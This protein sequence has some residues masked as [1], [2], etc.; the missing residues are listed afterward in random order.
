MF[1]ETLEAVQSSP[2]RR[3][4]YVRL[5]LAALALMVLFKTVIRLAILTP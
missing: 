3:T 5:V 2:S 1:A 4:I